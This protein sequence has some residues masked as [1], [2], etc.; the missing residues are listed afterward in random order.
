MKH[1]R[2]LYIFAASK[3]DWDPMNETDYL[4]PHNAY[5]FKDV[6]NGNVIRIIRK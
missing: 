5:K 4:C 6:F 2:T 1:A 3:S